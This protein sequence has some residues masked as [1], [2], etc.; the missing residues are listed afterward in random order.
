MAVEIGKQIAELAQTENIHVCSGGDFV[1]EEQINEAAVHDILVMAGGLALVGLFMTMHFGSMFLAVVVAFRE[2]SFPLVTHF[3]YRVVLQVE[4][5]PLPPA[6]GH[7]RHHRHRSRRRVRLLRPSPESE[8]QHELH[9]NPHDYAVA[10]TRTFQKTGSAMFVTTTTSAC[11]FASNL[12]SMISALRI[13]GFSIAVC[14]SLNFV[15]T[16][17]H[18]PL[19]LG[20]QAQHGYKLRDSV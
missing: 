1:Y 20:G 13:F 3:V 17:H 8:L 4:Q 6:P 15:G 18:L 7:L 16:C 14:V 19:Q 9:S 11:S 12:A 5:V 10:L 2:L